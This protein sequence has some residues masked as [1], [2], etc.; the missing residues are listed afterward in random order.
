MSFSVAALMVLG[1]PATA[2]GATDP[3]LGTAGNY[4][5]LA[6]AT[7]TSTG[8]SWITG[9]IGLSPGTSVTGFPP[10]TSGHQDVANGAAVQAM[11][12]LT[13]AYNNAALA[14]PAV[15]LTGNL[16][17]RT[18]TPGTYKYSSS[19]GLNGTLTLDGGGFPTRLWIFQI[20]ST[21]TTASSSRVSLING[22]QP[23][24]VF[25][26]VGSSA[27]IGTSTTF[28]GNVM[29]SISISM[30]TGATL[31]GRALAR[32]GA[33]T[34]D[35]NRIIQPSGCGYPAPAFV[36][37]PPGSILPG[38]LG[39]GVDQ[40]ISFG[41]LGDKI[42]G[43]PPFDVA[44]T[45]SS[46]LPVTFTASGVCSVSGATVSLT[47]T[48]I[49]TITATQAGNDTFNPAPNV[50]QSFDVLSPSQFAQSVIDATSGMGL[51]PGTATSLTSKLEAYIASN[52]RGEGTA[53]C[54]Q[55]G[56]IVNSVSAQSGKH[57]T[58]A[59]ATILLADATR[60]ATASGC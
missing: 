17:G 13:S 11:S 51:M 7:V 26:Q 25:W 14:T 16:G 30:L 56:A 40:T 32:N 50:S 22:A 60:L 55:L 21:L 45:A 57:I 34:L 12:N 42:L 39:G 20:G 33:V 27:T 1:W 3:G 38:T 44:A 9:Q 48:A 15:D 4:A 49:C 5:V 19:A 36:A 47:G 53:A 52:A 46:G 58:A 28:A 6:G 2:L 10:G 59:D 35:T 8:P 37:A 31:Q 29:A 24:D 43:E 54:G 18:L 41:P 23:C